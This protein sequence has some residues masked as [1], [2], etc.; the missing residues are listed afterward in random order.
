MAFKIVWSELARQ[1]L[2]DI[3]EFIAR[4]NPPVAE[5]FGYLLIS[6]VD[7]LSEFPRLGR[8]VPEIRN[9][10]I[11]EIVFRSYRIVYRVD[12]ARRA[13]AVIRVWHGARGEPEIP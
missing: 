12:E 9:E 2:R 7:S 13:V 1:D 3:V 6:R 4:D 10:D 8:M 5:T 11:R